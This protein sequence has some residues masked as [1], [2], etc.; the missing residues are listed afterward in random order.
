MLHLNK[1]SMCS[2]GRATVSYFTDFYGLL[3][4]TPRINPRMRRSGNRQVR[5]NGGSRHHDPLD[6]FMETDHH[7]RPPFDGLSEALKTLGI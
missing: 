2:M 4:R 6:N 1:T 5:S 7:E 3:P